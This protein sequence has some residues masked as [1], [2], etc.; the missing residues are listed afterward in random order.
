MEEFGFGIGILLALFG[1]LLLLLFVWLLHRLV[2]RRLVRR[3]VGPVVSDAR[4]RWISVALSGFFVAGAVAV[5]YFPGKW[6]FDRMCAEHAAPVISERV[7]TSGYY[8]DR[9]FRYEAAQ[10]L[11]EG[12]FT[13]V[14]APDMYKRGRLLRYEKTDEGTVEEEEI[15]SPRSTYGVEKKFS[16][17]RF[18]ISM[19]RKRVY[20][21]DG[22]RE[23]AR[24]ANLIYHGGRLSL[25]LGVYGMS[26]CPDIRSTQGSEDFRTFYHL[27]ATVLAGRDGTVLR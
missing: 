21:M 27:E 1:P 7:T 13:F 6:E 18:G 3:L 10:I 16:Q 15:A 20:E 4:A 24:A 26:S 19:T 22:K 23:L 25:F 14:E 8:R 5:S 17:E 2:G 11:N 9:L 12:V